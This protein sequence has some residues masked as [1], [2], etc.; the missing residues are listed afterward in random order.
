MLYP[1]LATAARIFHKMAWGHEEDLRSIDGY[2]IGYI[3]Y[4]YS[5]AVGILSIT[6]KARNTEHAGSKVD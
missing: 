2:L 3:R 1:A 5:H 4:C 6:Q